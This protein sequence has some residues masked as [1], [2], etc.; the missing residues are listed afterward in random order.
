MRGAIIDVHVLTYGRMNKIELKHLR[1]ED[2]DK[3]LLKIYQ[4]SHCETIISY[5]PI[6][7]TVEWGY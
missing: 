4:K 7:E 3:F 1:K 2:S 5:R 6:T